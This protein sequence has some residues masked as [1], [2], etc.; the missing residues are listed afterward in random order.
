MIMSCTLH[1]TQVLQ[2]AGYTMHPRLWQAYP[3][4]RVDGVLDETGNRWA[5]APLLLQSS[6][7]EAALHQALKQG[8]VQVVTL[9]RLSLQIPWFV[10]LS[11][12]IM[13]SVTN[14]ATAQDAASN[15]IDT[16]LVYRDCSLTFQGGS[17]LHTG[18]LP[19]PESAGLLLHGQSMSSSDKKTCLQCVKLGLRAQLLMVSYQNEVLCGGSKAGQD[20]GLKH[21]SCLLH[22][23]HLRAR[24][25]ASA[26]LQAHKLVKAPNGVL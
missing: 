26:D 6:H 3:Q 23:D 20:V 17:D 13:R 4:V 11:C 24:G 8:A 1:I 2:K 12:C 25:D 7:W 19:S 5:H 10:K 16:L 18:G 9:P 22:N 21:F 15:C 14:A